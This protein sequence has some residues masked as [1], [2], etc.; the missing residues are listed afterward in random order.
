[1]TLRCMPPSGEALSLKPSFALVLP[2]LYVIFN[3]DMRIPLST[4][5]IL[6][7]LLNT[8]GPLPAGAQPVPP[9][10]GELVLPNPG[11]RIGLSPEFTP[12]HLKGI[13]IHQDNALRFDF[14]VHKGDQPLTDN[15]KKEE[16]NKLI[17]Y[18]LASLTIPDKDQWVNLS[19]YEKDRIIEGDFG[20]TEMGRDLLGQD[21]LL[22]QITA[23]LIYPEEGLGQKFWD[24]IY[25]RAF[26]QYGTTNIPVNTFN[27]V[28][29]VPD[30][31]VVY[32]SGNTAY[33]LQSHLKVML[34]E[35]YLSLEKHTGLSSPNANGLSFPNASVGNPGINKAHTLGSQVVREIVLP[36]LEKEINEDKNFAQLRQIYSAM[37]LATWYK[38][39]LKASLLGQVYADKA[40]VK[41][42]DQNPANNELI[43]QQYLKAF[44]KGVYSYIKEDTDKYTKQTIP[45]KYFSGGFTR[46][47][48]AA[49]LT[50]LHQG[51]VNGTAAD[52]TAKVFTGGRIERVEA[53]IE[54]PKDT[55]I[56]EG[57]VRS[58]QQS[59]A[60]ELSSRSSWEID[61]FKVTAPSVYAPILKDI[62][63]KLYQPRKL[64]A[65]DKVAPMRPVDVMTA[66]AAKLGVKGR[67]IR[68]VIG[69]LDYLDVSADEKAL[70]IS[71][72]KYELTN[73][74]M[75]F[76]GAIENI[77]RVQMANGGVVSVTK[78][79]AEQRTEEAR[80]IQQMFGRCLQ[81]EGAG[82]EIPV[83]F[84]RAYYRGVDLKRLAQLKEEGRFKGANSDS[85]FVHMEP[86]VWVTS[87]VG[88]AEI[89]GQK[90]RGIIFKLDKEA[91]DRDFKVEPGWQGWTVNEIRLQSN[92]EKPVEVPLTTHYISEII[93]FDQT[94]YDEAKRL[95]PEIFVIFISSPEEAQQ[96][97]VKNKE[98]T[99]VE[100]EE[101][102]SRPGHAAEFSGER[103]S[104]ANET[105]ILAGVS[106]DATYQELL[107]GLRQ[108]SA[109][110][111]EDLKGMVGLKGLSDEQIWRREYKTLPQIVDQL[112]KYGRLTEERKTQIQDNR[113]LRYNI[114][115]SLRS[116][117][118]LAILVAEAERF[119]S[120]VSV[121]DQALVATPGGIDL[122]SA[123]LD[124]QIKRDGKGVPLP[125]QLQDM[126]KLRSIEG[127]VPV[128]INIVPV[129]S[130]P[131]LSELQ[132]KSQS[133]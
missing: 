45:R 89:Y 101:Y 126:E 13:T 113:K 44:K 5:V 56:T 74:R 35:D 27:K 90:D 102:Y 83:A 26:K 54:V 82:Y 133:L 7:F 112:L 61:G 16:Y 104:L 124:L 18:F 129:T 73:P 28:W 43:Y 30:K 87:D 8:L 29:I 121:T 63:G 86:S 4:L 21:Y 92:N 130:L 108:E 32:E 37:I 46:G 34:E 53:S 76:S 12:A 2:Y 77:L 10:A 24:T 55:A 119:R 88:V 114:D 17:K 33:I 70:E 72:S 49:M 47:P 65:G 20:K 117:E 39:A 111:L 93:V 105:L 95:F 84:H 110:A 22:K 106:P 118:S 97:L 42:V 109:R 64:Y 3:I 81:N 36:A 41:G 75:G 52:E 99:N 94:S 9:Q 14:L 123:N 15:D 103:F 85:L 67:E 23:S 115:E 120:A 78:L 116:A 128:I 62:L 60:E 122:N 107:V 91:V 132:G 69:D 66:T 11:V 38:K 58:Q 71:I 40:K 57:Q 59:L 125:L 25:E 51:E 1:M 98:M 6:A 31:A 79:V 131:F 80:R 100:L 50:I 96:Y 19:P 68:V 48:D 127:F